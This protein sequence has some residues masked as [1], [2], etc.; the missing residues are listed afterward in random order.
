MCRNRFKNKSSKQWKNRLGFIR[1]CYC[2]HTVKI[3]SAH[4][5]GLR[6]FRPIWKRLF[7][8]KHVQNFY[9]LKLTESKRFDTEV[10]W[11]EKHFIFYYSNSWMVFPD[12]KMCFRPKN[13]FFIWFS[14]NSGQ[15][16]LIPQIFPIELKPLR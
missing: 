6:P 9:V 15:A 1:Y 14:E 11:T 16:S 5:R 3:S 7:R 4:V 12:P 13:F 2:E 10:D 8:E